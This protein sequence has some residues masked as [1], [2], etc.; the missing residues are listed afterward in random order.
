MLFRSQLWTLTINPWS[1]DATY[2]IQTSIAC[3][4]SSKNTY[5]TTAL[6][7]GSTYLGGTMQIVQSSNN[8]ATLTFSVTDKPNTTGPVTYS[9]RIGISAS[10]PWY[11][12]RRSTE[13]TYGGMQTGLV[14]WEY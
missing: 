2:V 7:R 8:S 1:T 6:F 13:I 3:A 12:N 5:I 14:M 10:P 11:V 4:G 9:V